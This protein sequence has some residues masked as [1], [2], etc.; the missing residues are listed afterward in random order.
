MR[1]FLL[2]PTVAVAA[3]TLAAPGHALPAA[4]DAGCYV[5]ADNP[6]SSKGSP[7]W[8]VGKAR[9]M[10]DQN[11]DSLTVIAELQQSVNGTWVVR[12]RPPDVTYSRPRAGNKYTGQATVP[13]KTGESGTFRTAASGHGVYGGSPSGSWAWKYSAEV[14]LTC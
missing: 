10:C 12:D 9:I 11:I 14:N 6:H 8:I 1:T 13:C 7:G 3:S 5:S 2:I 4:G